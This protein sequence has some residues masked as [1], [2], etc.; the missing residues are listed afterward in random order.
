M[1]PFE[2]RHRRHT[3]RA[4]VSA[5]QSQFLQQSHSCRAL[6]FFRASPIFRIRKLTRETCDDLHKVPRRRAGPADNREQYR[7]MQQKRDERPF[8]GEYDHHFEPGIYVDIVSGEPLFASSAKFNSGRV[9]L[10]QAYR[11]C[12]RTFRHVLRCGGSRCGQ[13]TAIAIWAM[14]STM[15]RA[16]GAAYAIA[17]TR[18]AFG[19]AEGRHGSPGVWAISRSGGGEEMTERAV[20]GRWLLLGSKKK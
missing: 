13:N 15:A 1:A 8:T 10:F 19:H 11:Q 2:I 7:V 4:V 18:P 5:G 20:L 14:C 3:S 9:C 16:R 6:A 17:S 12:D